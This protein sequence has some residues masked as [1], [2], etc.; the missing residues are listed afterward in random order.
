VGRAACHAI[1]L[2]DAPNTAA[3]GVAGR[4]I[5]HQ[6]AEA[7]QFASS[8]LVPQDVLIERARA[9]SLQELFDSLDEFGVST[10]ATML[11]LRMALM[12][13]FA[14]LFDDAEPR[15]LESSGTELPRGAWG[16]GLR[17]R[18]LAHDSGDFE[19]GGRTVRWYL[20]N[21]PETFEPVDDT[22]TTSELLWGAIGA[23]ELPEAA[24]IKLFQ[25]ING[26][27]AGKLSIDRATTIDQALT[28]VR[29]TTRDHPTIPSEVLQ[30]PDF[31]AY[32]RRKVE[33]RMLK[34]GR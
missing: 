7:T 27:V 28:I 6:E 29:G 34:H 12:P 25:S 23:V 20:V 9:S 3:F 33:E 2:E 21:E 31:D 13:G 10:M 15:C 11:A 16:N 4:Q 24:S 26:I 14:F 19:C 30:H 32:L 5:A 1:S 18:R 17:L 22:R 8:L